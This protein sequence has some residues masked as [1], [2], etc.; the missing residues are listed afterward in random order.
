MSF[1]YNAGNKFAISN[2]FSEKLL[3]SLIQNKNAQMREVQIWEHELYELG[4]DPSSSFSAGPITF[5]FHMY[6]YLD[7][8][9]PSDYPFKPPEYNFACIVI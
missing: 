1:V 7:I 9:L 5:K 2:L 4:R 3:T 8:R 6:V